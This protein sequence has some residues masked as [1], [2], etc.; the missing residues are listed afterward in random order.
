MGAAPGIAGSREPEIDGVFVCA[1][2]FDAGFFIR[3]NNT[4]GPVDLW[5]IDGIDEE[6]LL[7]TGSRFSYYPGPITAGSLTLARESLPPASP[8]ADTHPSTAY[9]SNLTITMDDGTVMFD[10]EARA[11]IERH[12]T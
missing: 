2:E 1:S 12:R 9:R 10:D 4:G 11:F 6:Q 3:M 8:H 5:I 7:T